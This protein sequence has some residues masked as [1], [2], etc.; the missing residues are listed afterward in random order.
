MKQCLLTVCFTAQL[1]DREARLLETES[2]QKTLAQELEN[3]QIE[4][5]NICRQKSLVSVL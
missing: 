2:I 5:E 4:L 3:T 1:E